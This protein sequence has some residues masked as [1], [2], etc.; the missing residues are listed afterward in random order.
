VLSL[1]A[2]LKVKLAVTS[3]TS[4]GSNNDKA[5]AGSIE[6]LARCK[7]LEFQEAWITHQ[8]TKLDRVMKEVGSLVL[9]NDYYGSEIAF[10]MEWLRFYTGYLTVPALTGTSLFAL[11][12]MRGEVDSKWNP[13]FNILMCIWGS[14]FIE[15]WKRRSSELGNVWAVEDAEELMDATDLQKRR[16]EQG[17]KVNSNNNNNN[18]D[19]E[20]YWA[21]HLEY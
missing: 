16:A 3:D 8:V 19:F 18:I 6:V 14:L 21:K 11:Q 15:S 13:L 4:L 2:K 7:G 12:W 10:Y 17:A 1:S 20:I 9:L 5:E